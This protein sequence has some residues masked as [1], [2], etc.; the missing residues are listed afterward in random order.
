MRCDGR[1]LEFAS[2]A[3]RRDHAVVATAVCRNAAALK[4]VCADLQVGFAPW[5]ARIVAL[6]LL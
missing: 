1:A 6:Y 3:M 2:S 4:F 5:F